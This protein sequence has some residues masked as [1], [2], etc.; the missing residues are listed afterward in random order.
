[1]SK[2]TLTLELQSERVTTFPAPPVLTLMGNSTEPSPTLPWQTQYQQVSQ[3]SL[4]KSTSLNTSQSLPSQNQSLA[5]QQL[6][7]ISMIKVKELLERKDQ[8]I[9]A[10]QERASR[11]EEEVEELTEL[12]VLSVCTT[13]PMS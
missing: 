6:D 7:S 11:K 1:M 8:K 5:T 10:L 4:N 12:T 3:H 2:E 13:V 9:K